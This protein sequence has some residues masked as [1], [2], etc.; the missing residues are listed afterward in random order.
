M[1]YLKLFIVT[2]TGWDAVP[3]TI[4][5]YCIRMGCSTSNY[6]LLLYQ[7]GMQHL[8][9]NGNLCTTTSQHQHMSVST[10]TNSNVSTI[11]NPWSIVLLQKL[12]DPQ[13]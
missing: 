7:N 6:L 8:K 3:Q 2:V 9:L 12:T 5:C 4:Y 1:Q 10:V 11:V 13:M